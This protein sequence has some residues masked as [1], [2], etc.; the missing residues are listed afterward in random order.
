MSRNSGAIFRGAA[1]LV[2]AAA[3]MAPAIAGRLEASMVGHVVIQIPLLA[4]AG[5][6]V[7]RAIAATPIA[8]PSRVLQSVN[9]SGI[10]GLIVAAFAVL[11]WMLP[12]SLDAALITPAAEVAKFVSVPLLIGVP[13][14]LSWHRLPSLVRGLVWANLVSMLAVL[15]WLYLA[16]PLRLCNNYLVS[17]QEQ[18]GSVLLTVAVGLGVFWVGHLFVVGAPSPSGEPD[19]D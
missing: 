1:G 2:V 18:L 5:W 15:G 14:S 16:S 8:A 13:L 17:Q 11:F 4:A 10:P 3:M 12:R 6:L 7:G 19:A 9:G